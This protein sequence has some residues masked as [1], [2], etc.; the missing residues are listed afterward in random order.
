M[1]IPDGFLSPVVWV[2]LYLV[3]IAVVGYSVKRANKRLGERHIPL[4]G[5]LAAF[6]FAAQMLN[7]PVAGGTSG[8]LLGGV[9]VA[10]LVGPFAGTIVMTVI[11]V[12]Q[13]IV[14]QDGGITALG[15]N[16]FNMGMIGTILGY[17]IYVT[18]RKI[19]KEDRGILVGAFVASWIAMVLGA[20]FVAVELAISGTSPIEIALP[21]MALIHGVT[22]IGEGFITVAVIGYILKVR[23]D[24]LEVEKI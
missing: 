20:I 12:V 22:G 5:V 2:P 21:A 15:A 13:A 6:V 23:P 10:V 9:L 24:I 4:M 11:F 19:I 3:S 16:I 17:Y 14:F 1:H 8:H 7:F 18:I